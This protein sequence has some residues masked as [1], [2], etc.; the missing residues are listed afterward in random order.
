MTPKKWNQDIDVLKELLPQNHINLFAKK[1]QKDFNKD[2]EIVK[3]NIT[4]D[5]AFQIALKLQTAVSKLG[6]SHTKINWD[7]FLNANENLPL[8]FYQFKDGIYITMTNDENKDLL[9]KKIT[10]INHF[11]VNVILDSISKTFN[12][13]N[14][15]MRKTLPIGYL[16]KTQVLKHYGFN[17]NNS[18]NIQFENEGKSDEKS[19][20]L[21]SNTKDNMSVINPKSKSFLRENKRKYF[22]KK[23]F[24]DTKILYILYNKCISK[25][26]PS[27]LRNKSKAIGYLPSFVE[28]ENSILDILKNQKV[29][30]IIFD[31][32]LNEGGSSYQ[33]TRLI[34]KILEYKS[35]NQK[36]KLFVVIGR[37]TYS[38]AIINALDF[39][40]SNAI[41]VGEETS[42]KPNHFGN[43]DSF[44]LPNS[45]LIVTYSMNYY[46]YLQEDVNSLKPDFL[47]EETFED[48]KN[49]IDPVFEFVKN[50]K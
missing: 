13:D 4:K 43:I 46:K 26:E 30:K 27:Y 2:L 34:Q 1:N 22:E 11:P 35:I 45:G 19:V 49:G 50:Y 24:E 47:I 16:G 29:D 3:L 6:D 38:S 10:G 42:G 36:G 14:S 15:G 17:K 28:F 31:V 12:I 25:E 33:G 44:F 48:Y 39:K 7:K 18:I 5:S 21:T 40:K 20:I 37:E 23:Y 32:R 9:G 41:Y 8:R